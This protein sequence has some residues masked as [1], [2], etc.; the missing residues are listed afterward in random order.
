MP[1]GQTVSAPDGHDRAVRLWLFVIAVLVFAMVVVGGATRLTDSG[2]S[3]TEWRPLM[4][5]I[6]PL[7]H[8]Q[9]LVEF[10]KYRASPQYDAI[11][12]G[13]SLGN[14]QFIYWW[15][16]AHRLLGRLIGAAMLLPWLFFVAKGWLKGRLAAV[17]FGIGLMIGLQGLVGWLMVA[18]GLNPGMVAVAPLKLM[19]HLTLA[20]VIFAAL[21]W[22]ALGLG[23]Q[24][25]RSPAP[26]RLRA[27]GI[28]ILVLLFVQIML[29]A[30]VA[31]NDAGMRF[32]DWPLMDGALVP[33]L[34]QLFDKPS[35]LEAFVDSL[36]LTQF[37]HRLGAYALF[38]L[39]IWH[40]LSARGTG[41]AKGAVVQLGLVTA[42]AIIGITALVLVV[43]L[44]AGLLHQAFAVLVLGHVVAHVHGLT[45]A[46]RMPEQPAAQV[47]SAA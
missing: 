27:G 9:W 46:P 4:G 3:I 29:G 26:V 32:N 16:W 42:Q 39:A 17:T 5:A 14:F 1:A 40:M 15:E 38:A 21:I 20:C 47:L 43:P 41:F 18:S 37:N 12:R 34:E 8:D 7:S 36:A 33:P 31:G 23:A 25:E 10:A 24:R 22:V 19:F 35:T 11:N 28:A 45:R 13:M 44:W 30:L 2:L 6:P